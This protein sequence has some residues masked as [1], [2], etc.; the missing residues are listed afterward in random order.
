MQD[1]RFDR[2][3]D[4]K[5]VA[6][7]LGARSTVWFA[8]A[9]YVAAVLVLLICAPWPASGAAFAILPYLATVAAYLRVDDATAEVTH[10]GWTRFLVL[11]MLA[12]FCVTQLVLWSV[13][14]W[15]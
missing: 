13:L 1:V 4:L 8:L 2:E 10:E 15:A 9:C 7:V 12:G 14:V 11:N 6:T 5:S 3:A